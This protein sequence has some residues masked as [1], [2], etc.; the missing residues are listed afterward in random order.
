VIRRQKYTVDESAGAGVTAQSHRVR[1][2]LFP[3]LQIS[4]PSASFQV[5]PLLLSP[6]M[7][8]LALTV[9]L[10]ATRLHP[11][12]LCCSHYQ[13]HRSYS[14]TPPSCSLVLRSAARSATGRCAFFT[15]I[16]DVEASAQ[17]TFSHLLILLLFL[18]PLLPDQGSS[19]PASSC[20]TGC[21]PRCC[22]RSAPSSPSIRR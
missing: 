7:G 18:I 4:P 1:E 8:D 11:S 20:C 12:T 17:S 6:P 2:L 3:L 9:T 21:P 5:C 22:L 15:V 13:H 10:S 14:P 19:A 16:C